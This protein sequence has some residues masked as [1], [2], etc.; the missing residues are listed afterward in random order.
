MFVQVIFPIADIRPFVD[1]ATHRANLP[2]WPDATPNEHFVRSVGGVKRRKKG[3]VQE[4]SGERLY[5]LTENAFRFRPSG[6]ETMF[7]LVSQDTRTFDC[8]GRRLFCTGDVAT[9]LEVSF[10]NGAIDADRC[11]DPSRS[12]FDLLREVLSISV[13]ARILN[14]TSEIGPLECLGPAFASHYLASTTKRTKRFH[15]HWVVSG[16]PLVVVGHAP[17]EMVIP[18]SAVPIDIP[19]SNGIRLLHARLGPTSV[20][21]VEVGSAADAAELRNLRIHLCRIHTERECL[22]I[23]LDMIGRRYIEPVPEGEALNRLHDYLNESERGLRRTNRFGLP[24]TALLQSAYVSESLV[25]PGACADLFSALTRAKKTLQW[26]LKRLVN[27]SFVN[28]GEMFFNI[29]GSQVSGGQYINPQG[30]A[31][32]PNA[33]ATAASVQQVQVN[34]AAPVSIDMAELARQLSTLRGH[35]T[36]VAKTADECVVVGEVASAEKAAENKDAVGL[37]G[38]LKKAGAWAFKC[39]TDIGVA[40]AADAINRAMR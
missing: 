17:R 38:H 25:D 13:Q 7:R 5:C 28:N 6:R 14:R 29:G 8:V 1:E 22:R 2:T 15:T 9:R 26:K 31:I 24:Q 30:Q 33:Q 35:L 18:D 27:S 3:G 11:Q 4:W 36:S 19:I 16:R 32:G 40:V 34:L 23:V 12:F 37:L 21:F 39:A 20:W 10:S